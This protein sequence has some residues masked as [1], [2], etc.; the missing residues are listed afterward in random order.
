M[1]SPLIMKHLARP[2]PSTS[3]SLVA[4]DSSKWGWSFLPGRSARGL[5]LVHLQYA[6]S[7]VS[8]T[9]VSLAKKRKKERK[10][11]QRNKNGTHKWTPTFPERGAA[12]Q[13]GPSSQRYCWVTAR[14]ETRKP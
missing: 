10:K 1:K 2:R 12:R 14:D 4:S 9:K 7:S 13:G 5:L 6:K 3:V 11:N 8:R